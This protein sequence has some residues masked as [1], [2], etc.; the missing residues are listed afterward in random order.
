MIEP[1]IGVPFRR[2]APSLIEPSIDAATGHASFVFNTE[3]VGR[4]GHIVRNSGIQAD[5][6]RSNPVILFCHDDK[7][8]PV[9]RAVNL[10]IGNSESRVTVQF[11]PRDL[12]PFGATVGELVKARYLNAVSE[13]WNP[14]KYKLRPGGD[15]VDFLEVDLLE[16]SIV[17]IPALPQAIATA[18]SAGIDTAP[19]FEWAQKIL[20]AGGITTIKRSELETLRLAAKMPPRR[21]TSGT[22]PKEIKLKEKLAK[23]LARAP[24]VP[25]FKRGLYGVAQLAYMVQ[26]LGYLH[27]CSSIEEEIEG[28]ESEVPGMV[29]EALV[30]LGKSLVAMTKEEVAELLE[31]NG[32]EVDEIEERGLSASFSASTRAWIR[33][34]KSPAVRAWRLGIAYARD[35]E[36][37]DSDNTDKLAEAHEQHKRA[38]K[39]HRE[40]GEHQ[41]AVG[42]H[43]DD[44]RS[45]HSDATEQH[46]HMGEALAAAK[47]AAHSDSPKE[48][49]GHIDRAIDHYSQAEGHIAE[50]AAA[51]KDAKDRCEDAG[52]KHRALG[53]ALTSAT[54]CVRSVMDSSEPAS[55][56]DEKLAE[57]E[58][59]RT[60]AALA[61]RRNLRKPPPATPAAAAAT[62]PVQPTAP[63]GGAAV[64]PDR[65]RRRRIAIALSLVNPDQL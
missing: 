5:N 23:H 6:F 4:D 37:V 39:N 42:D 53:R 52:D 14:I 26:Q 64:D 57:E 34:A 27:D 8:P 28:D 30:A 59:A 61:V 49:R 17:P 38:A 65:D 33:S 12:Y 46:H 3:D 51:H 11:T 31:G 25:T 19:M 10:A 20:D 35:V 60:A 62:P 18:R 29:G 54:S 45:A 9:G 15:G 55:E 47:T 58:K 56:G 16:I 36:N 7:S 32:L 43:L 41:E 2:L 24:K 44:A 48:A 40:L 22:P 21:R 50:V 1:V 13:S 63:A